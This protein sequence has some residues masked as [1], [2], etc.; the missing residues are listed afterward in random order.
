MIS[1]KKKKKEQEETQVHAK[2]NVLK[3]KMMISF[4]CFSKLT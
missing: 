3:S 1:R 2:K 4:Q